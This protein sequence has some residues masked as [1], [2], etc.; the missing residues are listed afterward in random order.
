MTQN[1]YFTSDTHFFHSQV[2]NFC[3]RPFNCVEEMN[4][5]LV[6]NWNK[7]VKPG[8]L[9]YILGD[10]SFGNVQDTNQILSRLNGQK[11][12]IYGN[13]DQLIRKKKELQ[14][15]FVWCKDLARIKPLINNEK[16]DIV[17]CHYAM[18]VWEKSHYGSWQLFGHSHGGLS[19]HGE[20]VIP[21]HSLQVDVGVDVWNY[22]PVSIKEIKKFMN[23]KIEIYTNSN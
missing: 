11:Y 4:E 22:T 23:R 6:Q 19:D 14:E 17:L 18:R 13:H 10:V 3:K 21:V 1:I 16:Q 9:I 15:H 12:L 5:Q 20:D 7:T 2:I 8:D